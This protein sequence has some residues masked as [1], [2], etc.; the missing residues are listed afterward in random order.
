M[1]A[2]GQSLHAIWGQAGW[3]VSAMRTL[4]ECGL[5][6]EGPYCKSGAGAGAWLQALQP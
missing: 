5:C 3:L 4:L 6:S 1:L 2:A